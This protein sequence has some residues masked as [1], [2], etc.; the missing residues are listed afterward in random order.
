[1]GWGGKENVEES[2]RNKKIKSLR[3]ET[4]KKL[5]KMAKFMYISTSINTTM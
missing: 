4:G 1:L 5:G 2:G 3:A